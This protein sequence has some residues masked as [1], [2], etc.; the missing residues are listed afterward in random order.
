MKLPTLAQHLLPRF[1]HSRP[2]LVLALGFG[3]A[4][5]LFLPASQGWVTR[6]VG[7]WNAA[8]WSYLAFMLRE[9]LKS[10]PGRVHAL[11][12]EQDENGGTILFALCLAAVLS[13]TAIVGELGNIS[14]LPEQQR[15]ARYGFTAAT[16][17]GS[18]FLVGT[19]FAFHY[20]HLYY[21]ADSRKRP[22]NFPEGCDEPDYWDFLY[23]SFTI[24]VAAQTADVQIMNG[25]MRRLVLGQAVLAFAFNLVII[26]LSINIGAS[27]INN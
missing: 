13:I 24:G 8:C 17:F 4:V 25:P 27:L 18:W 19:V 12:R 10:P 15:A 16:I 6:A 9:V 26:G 11:A 21:R 20:A 2:H 1:L 3:I 23:F 5:A 14:H 22:F 7:G